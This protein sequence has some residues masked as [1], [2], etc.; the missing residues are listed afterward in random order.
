PQTAKE[1]QP[2]RQTLFA[3]PVDSGFL[4]RRTPARKTQPAAVRQRITQSVKLPCAKQDGPPSSHPLPRSL[5][6]GP[7]ESE[8]Q[9]SRAEVE[10]AQS[11]PRRDSR[12]LTPD[13]WR[14]GLY[15]CPRQ[16]DTAVRDPGPSL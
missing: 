13:R 9:P 3:L 10:T 2:E 6:S 14:A 7:F 5:V 12:W 8:P 4:G 16:L 1:S 11:S 15:A